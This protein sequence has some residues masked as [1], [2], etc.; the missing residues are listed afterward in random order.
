MKKVSLLHIY[1][2]LGIYF[3][4]FIIGYLISNI[5][6]DNHFGYY[7][8]NLKENHIS[9]STFLSIFINNI[10]VFI[11]LLTGIILWKIPTVI[12]LISNGAVLG[13]FLGGIS[14]NYLM[15]VLPPLLIHGVPE[16]IS[17]FI[18]SYIAFI[19]KE[20]FVQHKILNIGLLFSGVIILL[21]AA[22]LETYISP[23]Y[24]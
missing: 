14:S 23:I 24:V 11:I 17:F 2:V 10:K 1:Y 20:R 5:L 16:L 22:F 6:L 9:F 12:N 15:N 7:A 19:G 4:A 8:Q 21:L 3:G 13:Y 18:A